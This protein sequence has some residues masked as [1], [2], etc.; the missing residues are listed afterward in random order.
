[1]VANEVYE[2]SKSTQGLAATMK[3]ELK[4]MTDGIMTSYDKLK[5]VATV[6]LSDNILA[7]ERLETVLG[8]LVRR[9][10]GIK[11]S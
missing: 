1:M 4:A 9:N 3:S 11:R 8:A 10:S 2:L 5:R 6:D 7:K